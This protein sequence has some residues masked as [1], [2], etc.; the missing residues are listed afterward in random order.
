MPRRKP[1]SKRLR[2]IE[3]WTEKKTAKGNCYL[4]CQTDQGVVAFWGR[5]GETGNISEVRR[6]STPFIVIC[7]CIPSNWPRHSFWIPQGSQLRFE[8]AA[9]DGVSIEELG[10]WRR[11][12]ARLLEKLGGLWARRQHP[13]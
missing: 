1:E 8:S 3:I 12:V 2:I 13:A 10:R 9:E 7:D 4:E 11:G 5:V 6:R